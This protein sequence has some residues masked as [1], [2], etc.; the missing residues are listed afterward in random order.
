MNAA[1]RLVNFG[2]VKAHRGN[3]VIENF[4][5]RALRGA[6]VEGGNIADREK[7]VF[8]NDACK[9]RL[10]LIPKNASFVIIIAVHKIRA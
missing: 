7:R 5:I 6:V 2:A 10:H 9:E 4:L 3:F 8:T 1:L